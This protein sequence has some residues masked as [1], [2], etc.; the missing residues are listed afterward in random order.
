[1]F[2]YLFIYVLKWV[3]ILKK[4]GIYF[5]YKFTFV[6]MS[7]NQPVR[8]FRVL[9]ICHGLALSK[10]RIKK[11]KFNANALILMASVSDGIER[12]EFASQSMFVGISI[13]ISIFV[14]F[15]FLFFFSKRF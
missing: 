14:F 6:R 1:M 4:L 8:Q 11:K 10:M 5:K 2:I 7:A 3:Q 9:Y 13:F 12:L 15:L